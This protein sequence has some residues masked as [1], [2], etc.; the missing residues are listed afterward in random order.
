[1]RAN[2]GLGLAADDCAASRKTDGDNETICPVRPAAPE[3]PDAPAGDGESRRCHGHRAGHRTARRRSAPDRLYRRERPVPRRAV[4]RSLL[5]ASNHES[6]HQ[7]LAPASVEPKTPAPHWRQ[8]TTAAAPP[9]NPRCAAIEQPAHRPTAQRLVAQATQ[10]L[11]YRSGANLAHAA[12]ATGATDADAL[13]ASPGAGDWSPASLNRAAS[14]LKR[15][16]GSG[17]APR[18]GPG[19]NHPAPATVAAEDRGA[20]PTHRAGRR[21]TLQ[22]QTA[23]AA[24]A[25]AATPA[26]PAQRLGKTAA[27]RKASAQESAPDHCRAHS[28]PATGFATVRADARRTRWPMSFYQSPLVH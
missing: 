18:P 4:A 15:T 28:S 24:D 11:P 5:P 7:H 22:R 1:M 3:T 21:A 26:P 27:N 16:A 20:A 23:D 17:R 12:P 2:A 19:G 8:A 6:A 13:D 25:D 14:G 10:C 9:P